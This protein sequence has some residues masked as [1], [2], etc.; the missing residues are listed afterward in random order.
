MR[1]I[2]QAQALLGFAF[3]HHQGQALP[4]R[5]LVCIDTPAWYFRWLQG[6]PAHRMMKDT[7]LEFCGIA[8]V[9]ISE[10]APVIKS[11]LAQRERWLAEA[12][13]LGAR[14]A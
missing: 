1:L 4:E 9:R 7:V 11:T 13:R 10:F 3:R 14:G 8:P 5:L 2:L 6:A 12:G